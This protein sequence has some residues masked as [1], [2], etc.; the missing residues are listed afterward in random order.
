MKDACKAIKLLHDCTSLMLMMPQKL[1]NF[2]M[3]TAISV[4]WDR[5]I[6]PSCLKERGGSAAALVPRISYLSHSSQSL[7]VFQI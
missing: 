4:G 5:Y 6:P 2:S 3:D 1:Q 7:A